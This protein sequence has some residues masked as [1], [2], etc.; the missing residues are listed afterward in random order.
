MSP[1]MIGVIGLCILLIC[2][3]SRM[4]IGLA[5]ASIGFFG[6]AYI[7]GMKSALGMMGSNPYN[8]IAYYPITVVPL[9]VFMGAI[10]SNSGM[11]TNL[12]NSGYKW[13]GQMRG[14]LCVATVAACA[15]FAA[16]CGSSMAETL[17][18]GK[19]ALPEMKKYKYDDSLSSG[20]VACAGSLAILIPPSM[21]FVLY[22]ILTE[23][24][25]GVLFMA[26]VLP[27]ILL[28]ALFILVIMVVT[29]RNPKLAPPGLRTPFKEK[30]LSLKITWVVVVLFLLVLGGIYTGIFTPTEAGAIGAFGA[31]VIT[32]ISRQ[33]DFKTLLASIAEAGV[34]T[35]MIMILIIG[36]FIFMKFMA[37]SKL[38]FVLAGTISG[39]G[40]SPYVILAFIV[41]IYIILGMLLEINSAMVLTI[42]LIYPVITALGFDPIWFG[43]IVV[44]L[45]EMG[46]AT[47]P[48]G[49]NVFILATVTDTPMGTIFR[50]VW[51]FVAAML[52]CIIILTIWPQIVLFLPSKM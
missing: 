52:I 33:L 1:E 3:F 25:V 35:A 48:V 21:G 6:F 51:P 45:M 15:L 23:Q 9:F 32:F 16:M 11:G 5:M 49:M 47:P 37:I 50:G 19:I 44:I 34:T 46:L 17:T 4:N 7:S 13:F 8:T 40:L 43:V 31:I 29:L 22:G 39:L 20:C 42:P 10:I 24:S 12:F 2:I 14:G 41:I 18:I 26:G 27:G 38:P 36:A 28:S 30:I